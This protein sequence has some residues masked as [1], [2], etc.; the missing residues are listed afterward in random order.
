MAVTIKSIAKV[1][2]VSHT[3]VSRALRGHPAIAQ[4][5]TARIH[6]IANELGYVPNTVAR[7]LKTSR[8]HVLG[9]VV[10]RIV[11]P[12][13]SE[14]LN[15]IEDVLH[16]EGYSLFLASSNRD[17]K[18]EKAIVRTMSE[19]RVEGVIFCSTQV[20]QE[21]QRYLERLGVPRVLINNQD[22]GDTLAYSI[23]HDD[24]YGSYELTHYLI[25]LG[26]RRI[27]YL[28]NQRGGRTSED[29]RQ[30][31]EQALQ[32]AGLPV[33][34]GYVVNGP[35]GVPAGGAESAGQFLAL[36]ERPTAIVCYNDMMAIGAIRTLIEAGLRVPDDCSITGFDNVELSA[37]VTPPL[38][39]FDQPKYELGRQAATMMLRLL[40]DR[41]AAP[42]TSI[43]VLRGKLCIRDS[44]G[45]PP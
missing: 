38:T 29:R 18:R 39:T 21:H 11:D 33:Q 16:A 7:G 4:E 36:A 2:N 8:S 34:P 20:G 9:V 41:T 17:P 10:R 44:A 24:V 43:K 32:E 3:T 6:Q 23:F 14:V 1:A 19:R 35:N 5:T 30:G 15:G 37:Y 40:E 12:F 25:G 42:E 31:Y 45:P 27:A 22:P 26:H 13:F 28:G